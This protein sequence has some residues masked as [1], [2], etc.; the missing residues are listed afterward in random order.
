MNLLSGCAIANGMP[1]KP[2]PVPKSSTSDLSIYLEIDR[3]SC[4]CFV[5]ISLVSEID[6]KLIFYSILQEINH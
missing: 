3:L 6:V 4:M 5:K 2:A 1:G